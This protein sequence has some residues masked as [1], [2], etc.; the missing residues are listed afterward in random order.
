M[1]VLIRTSPAPV[2]GTTSTVRDGGDPKNFVEF[3]VVHDERKSAYDSIA[4]LG[5]SI[6]RARFRG[7][8]NMSDRRFDGD[9]Q[10]EP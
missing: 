5:R 9:Q 3:D 8:S 7:S 6:S 2:S 10:V 1:L 4:K